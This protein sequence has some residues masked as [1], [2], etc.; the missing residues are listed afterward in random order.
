MALISIFLRPI[1]ADPGADARGSRQ[2]LPSKVNGV[3]RELGQMVAI[4]TE[5]PEI[6][7][8]RSQIVV[9]QVDRFV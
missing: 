5:E 9:R 1:V 4:A 3:V 2:A 7:D 8:R 6:H